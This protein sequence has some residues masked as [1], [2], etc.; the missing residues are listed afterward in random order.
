MEKQKKDCLGP[1]GVFI[2]RTVQTLQG[3]KPATRA[4][5][6]STAPGGCSPMPHVPGPTRESGTSEPRGR[7]GAARALRR[8]WRTV[9]PIGANGQ[10][11]G[12]RWTSGSWRPAM[13][14]EVV[15]VVVVALPR[16]PGGRA[17]GAAV[18]PLC[19]QRGQGGHTGPQVVGEAERACGRATRLPAPRTDTRIM[20]GSVLRASHRAV[21]EWGAVNSSE[22]ITFVA[23]GSF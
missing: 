20:T 3:L 10:N 4:A 15:V 16:G 7:A 13:G 1:P 19:R 23:A 22:G 14:L 9:W 18:R 5:T 11:R 6:C 12:T 21:R 17:S 8:R 2:P